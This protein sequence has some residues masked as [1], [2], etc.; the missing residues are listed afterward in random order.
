MLKLYV[1]VRRDLPVS[2]QAV[3]AAHA[4]SVYCGKRTGAYEKTTLILLSV[5]DEDALHALSQQAFYAD[6]ECD[7]F[8]E[9][10]LNA[11]LT[12]LCLSEKAKRLCARLPLAFSEPRRY[13]GS[14]LT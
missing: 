9:P 4:V 1:V 6:V 10:D 12:A 3:Q 11:T 13:E 7:G 5:A 14:V 8:Y 2:Q